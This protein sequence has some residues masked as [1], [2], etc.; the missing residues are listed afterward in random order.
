VTTDR[1]RPTP[2]PRKPWIAPRLARLDAG[3]AR[4]SINPARED[5]TF[6]FGS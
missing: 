5:G 6:S 4:N 1:T 3:D 2:V